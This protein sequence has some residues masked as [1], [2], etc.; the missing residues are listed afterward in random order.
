MQKRNKQMEKIQQQPKMQNK[1]KEN[2]LKAKAE[3]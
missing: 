2:K 1:L 3:K